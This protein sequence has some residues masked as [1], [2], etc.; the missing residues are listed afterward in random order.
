MASRALSYHSST[1]YHNLAS[2]LHLGLKFSVKLSHTC[3]PL[4]IIRNIL[5]FRISRTWIS[6]IFC[7]FKIKLV[8]SCGAIWGF[9]YCVRWVAAWSSSKFV[10]AFWYRFAAYCQLNCRCKCDF[11]FSKTYRLNILLILEMPKKFRVTFV[12]VSRNTDHTSSTLQ[13]PILAA[14]RASSHSYAGT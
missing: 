13:C 3:Q 7:F 10:F 1:H 6:G 11:S 9:M 14:L 5:F 8:L 2:P 12:M 4:R